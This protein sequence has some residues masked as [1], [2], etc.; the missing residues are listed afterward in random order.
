MRLH[1]VH[2]R[3]KNL[4]HDVVPMVRMRPFS[5]WAVPVV[6]APM[7]RENQ[8]Q[9]RPPPVANQCVRKSIRRI[10]DVHPCAAIQMEINRIDECVD[11]PING[12]SIAIYSKYLTV[13]TSDSIP[14]MCW[15]S[16]RQF[17]NGNSLSWME[18]MTIN[19]KRLNAKSCDVWCEK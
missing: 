11:D 6:G 13:N 12:Y 1:I 4:C 3:R 8:F 16:I 17:W 7:A 2:R 19:C 10:Y 5:V 14:A 18:T 15:P 9:I